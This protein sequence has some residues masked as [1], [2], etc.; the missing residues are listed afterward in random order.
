M[1]KA[2]ISIAIIY[3]QFEMLEKYAYLLLILSLIDGLRIVSLEKEQIILLSFIA[4]F[5][6]LVNRIMHCLTYNNI[7]KYG[8]YVTIKIVSV[9]KVFQLAGNITKID[10]KGSSGAEADDEETMHLIKKAVKALLV[11]HKR[12]QM[13]QL[14]WNTVTT[15]V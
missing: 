2:K 1:R 3:S 13:L 5:Y 8:K 9:E 10:K 6:I 14:P 7:L 4:P 15:T 12:K 11:K